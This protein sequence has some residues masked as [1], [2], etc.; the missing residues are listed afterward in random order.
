[1]P[2]ITA[3][4]EEIVLIADRTYQTYESVDIQ[5]KDLEKITDEYFS[6]ISEALKTICK[7]F[8]HYDSPDQLIDN[9]QEHKNSI[10][11]TVY[12]GSI[13]RNRMALVP[14]V[15]ESYGIRFVGA[16]AY[17]RIVCQDKF[18]SKVLAKQFGVKVAKGVL[19][20]KISRIAFISELQFPL[21]I[22]PNLEGSSIGISSKSKVENL[23]DAVVLIEE[24]LEEH[25]QP[26]LVE[27]FIKGKEICICIV[28]TPHSINYLEAMEV[29][30][31]S[32]ESYFHDKLYTALDKH[33]SEEDVVH[34]RCTDL[35]SQKEIEGISEL[36]F[37]LGK[38]DFMRI[39]GRINEN[40]F[41]LIELTPDA[42]FGK[43]SSMVDAAKI[44][45]MS[46]SE[47]LNRI[48]HNALEH[49][50]TPYSNYKGN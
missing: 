3:I 41:V 37:S 36:L 7:K 20:D 39:D 28:G 43:G 38:M 30:Y 34:K 11:F 47:V 6:D 35:L 22:K 46:Y 40:G 26:V 10:V 21:V 25:K 14:A 4:H 44:N 17:A 16:D 13:S 12:G 48:I 18:L 5:G 31:P 1:M 49:Y 24:L 23:Q 45:G 9:I 42:Y 19:V 33:A 29:L 50:H 32:N 27:E 2:P 15:C 8:T